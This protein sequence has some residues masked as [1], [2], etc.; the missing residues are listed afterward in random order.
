[1][2]LAPKPPPSRGTTTRIFSR[3]AEKAE[4]RERVPDRM[5]LAGRRVERE[6]F[7][8]G[9]PGADITARLDGRAD[10]AVLA[11]ARSVQRGRRR[12]M[13]PRSPPCRRRPTRKQTLSGNCGSIGGAPSVSASATSTTAGR[14]RHLTVT[15]SAPSL[16][17]FRDSPMT[18][19]RI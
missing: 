15:A 4:L 8:S 2:F 19:A 14:G 1:M 5:R 3:R 12:R 9:I 13:P 11:R 10:P 18:I 6:F 17:A 7:L 16:A